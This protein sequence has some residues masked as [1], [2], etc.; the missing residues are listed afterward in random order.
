MKKGGRRRVDGSRK[1]GQQL[2]AVRLQRGLTQR[3]L[4]SLVG[5]SPAHI[6]VIETGKVTNPGIELV[7]RIA[8]VLGTTILIGS[9]PAHERSGGMLAYESPFQLE[10]DPHDATERAISEIARLLQDPALPA[11]RR[12]E[13][14]GHVLSY[15]EWQ[16]D[17]I[18][19][20]RPRSPNH[21]QRSA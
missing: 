21:A 7:Q 9:E 11:K 16:H 4:A 14:A 18:A 6:S 1:L 13:L 2:K 3:E 5:V 15:A 19:E 12:A 8:A 20:G 10:S 17:R